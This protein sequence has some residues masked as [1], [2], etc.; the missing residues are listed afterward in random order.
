[1]L[2]LLLIAL[3]GA[4]LLPL[5]ARYIGKGAGLLMALLPFGL[6]AGFV[7]L[8][9]IVE[10]GWVRGE[11]YA[12][13]PSMGLDFTLRLDGFSFLFCLL[14]TGIGGL[15]MIY[16]G[17]YLSDKGRGERSRFFTLILLFMTAMLGTVL[18]DNLLV[19]IMFWEATSILSFLIIGFEHKSSRSRRAANM[20][21]QIT[22]AGGLALVAATLM[23][24]HVI[25]TYSMAEAVLRADEIGAH[26]LAPGIVIAIM[27]AAFTKSAQFP[28]HFW[29]PNAMQAPT[30]ASAFLHSATMVKLGIY[31]LARFEPVIAEVSWGRATLVAVACITMAM[32]AI[33]ALRAESFKAALAYSTVASLGI[34]V[35]L[36]GLDGPRATVAMIGFL[37]AHALY[38]AALFFCAGSVLHATGK[39]VLRS[40]GGLWRPL[41]LTAAACAGASLSMAG[42]PPFL[43]FVSKEFLFEAQLASSWELVPLTIAVLVN[44]VMVGVAGVITLRPFFLKPKEKVEVHHGE[45]F[46]LVAPP[47]LLALLG[48][49][50]SL[51][52]DWITRV[53]LRPAVAAVYGQAVEVQLSVWHG[54]TPM[55]A[56]SAVVVSIGLLIIRF[57]RNIHLMLRNRVKIEQY[58]IENVWEYSVRSLVRFGIRMTKMIEHGDLRGYLI[59]MIAATTGFCVWAMATSGGPLRLPANDSA[60]RLPEILLMLLGLGGAF[61]AARSRNVLSSM[62]GVGLTGFTIAITFM[63]NGAPDLALTQFAV[64]ALVV[65][66][67]TA[68]LLGV[69]LVCNRTRSSKERQVDGLVALGFALTAFVA[70]VDMAAGRQASSVSQWI[71]EMSLSAGFGYNVVNVIL[72]DFRGFDTMGEVAV[73]AMAAL[74][75]TGL[76][77]RHKNSLVDHHPEK[78]VHYSFSVASSVLFWMLMIASLIILYRGHNLPGGGFVGG[79]TAA[80]AFAVLSLARGARAAEAFLRVSPRVLVGLGLLLTVGA[81]I[82]GMLTGNSA[83]FLTQLWWEPGGFLPKLGT[84]MVFDFGVYLVVL[85]AVVTF[86][87]GLQ[88]EG[89]R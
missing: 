6:L 84:T 67:I 41:P 82:P 40:L 35:M 79:L 15:V 20:A 4:C 13:A 47:L 18:A 70:Q 16:S 76:L 24:G 68:M 27:L 71:G 69:P 77:A 2:V 80:L 45:T 43:G 61:V 59:A 28:F 89:A 17:G 37:F 87:F 5:A 8:A 53:A 33:Q 10:R 22:A 86:L 83:A 42:I 54:L 85:G 44:A 73:I 75:G 1:M 7:G 51:N 81:G 23:I 66:L 50:L 60:L 9:P 48:L 26:P 72:V 64:E 57:W 62:L 49:T 14:I 34:L 25:G 52:P 74:L 36:V 19:M 30:P 78:V 32:A 38:K 3:I 31:L 88:R 58:S 29:L 55:L 46:S 12:W 65:V 21:L 11:G 39:G 63:L 56:L